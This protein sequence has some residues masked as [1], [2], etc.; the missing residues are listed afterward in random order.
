M[1]VHVL[2]HVPFEGIGHMQEWLTARGAE[3][4]VT[5]FYLPDARL[6]D[7][8]ACDLVIAMGGPMSVNDEA[9]LPWLVEEKGFIR[10]AIAAGVPVLGICLG[11]QL[12]ASALGARV[13][14]NGQAEIGWFPLEAIAQ[15]ES[16][17]CF[18]F[19]AHFSALHWHGETFELPA[20]ARHLAASA[21]CRNQAFQLGR[22]VIGLQFHPEITR[23]IV[24]ELLEECAGE[25]VPGPYVQS[26]AQLAAIPEEAYRE[27]HRLIEALLAYLLEPASVEAPA[28]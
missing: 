18:R 24:A 26:P 9:E 21:A 28:G 17:D 12:I 25:L 19:P 3:I 22:R 23:A 8:A 20:G 1:K 16:D 5:R 4:E 2:Q 14:G 11:A 15:P 7:P 6:P 13:Y 10:A 27:G